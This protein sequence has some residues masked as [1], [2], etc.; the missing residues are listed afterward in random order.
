LALLYSK[1]Q[2]PFGQLNETSEGNLL[3]LQL[4]QSKREQQGQRPLLAKSQQT[5]L[6]Q[7]LSKGLSVKVNLSQSKEKLLKE[8]NAFDVFLAFQG[9]ASSALEN[10]YAVLRT[11]SVLEHHEAA[12]D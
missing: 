12:H 6:N 2:N 5:F 4:V 7:N 1:L 10:P 11:Q 9:V 8:K 3:V